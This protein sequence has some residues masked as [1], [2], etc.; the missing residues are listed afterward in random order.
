MRLENTTPYAANFTLALDKQGHEQIVLVTK[1]TFV[2]SDTRGTPTL[3]AD[4]QLPLF[5]ADTFGA[6][7]ARDATVFE[8]DF[9]HFRPRCDVLCHA[10]AHAPNGQPATSV[11]V[12]IRLGQWAK[13]FTAH[14]SRIWLRSA[15]GHV[16]SDKRPF[17]QQDIGYDHA[18]GGIDPEAEDPAL[19]KTFQEN[20]VGLGYYPNSLNREGMALAQTSEFGLDAVSPDGGFTP[21]AFGPVGRSWLPRRTFG[22]TY[23]DAWLDNRVP[24]L[25]MDFDDR[26]FQASA[27]DQQIPYPTGGEP[28]E[29]VN[30]SPE[31]RLSGE[32]PRLQIV[33]TFERKSGRVTQR[34]ANLDTVLFLPE[35]RCMCLTWRT[36]ITAERDLFEFARAVIVERLLDGATHWPGGVKGGPHG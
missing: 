9:A 17:L 36:R 19:A 34:I 18:Y 22:G 21:M 16:P 35:D 11:D 27:A 23:D 3:V 33:V 14:G 32:I 31:G 13:K 2:L 7:P 24:L 28:V 5:E 25:P 26:Y 15:S 1:A 20:P 4:R 29:L 6:D 10:R 12:G 8:T 30:L